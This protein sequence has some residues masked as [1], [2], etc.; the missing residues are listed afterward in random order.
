MK[1][2]ILLVCTIVLF[3]SCSKSSSDT[4]VEPAQNRNLITRVET[5]RDGNTKIENI[6]YDGNK[7][8]EFTSS[9]TSKARYTYVGNLITNTQSFE[10]NVSTGTTSYTYTGDKLTGVYRTEISNGGTGTTYRSR[11]AFTHNNDGTINFIRYS[12]NSANVETQIGTGKYTFLNGNMIKEEYTCLTFNEIVTYTYDTKN[13]A[14]RNI[15]GSDKLIDNE[16][17]S[18]NNVLTSSQAKNETP[19][20]GTAYAT[21]LNNVYTYVYNTNNYITSEVRVQTSTNP[22]GPI[23]SSTQTKNYFY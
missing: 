7:I 6:S 11:N 23:P 19:V 16:Q 17:N 22:F 20:G 15:S 9:A 3:S 10:N 21:T 14:I 12:I 18:V 13:N 5:T 4:V 2:I 1:R 8:I